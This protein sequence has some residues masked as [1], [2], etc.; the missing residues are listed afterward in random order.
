MNKWKNSEK[1]RKNWEKLDTHKYLI[2]FMLF[3]LKN[4]TKFNTKGGGKLNNCGLRECDAG[5]LLS[6]PFRSID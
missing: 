5:F 6:T 1:L 4:K 2:D 3:V